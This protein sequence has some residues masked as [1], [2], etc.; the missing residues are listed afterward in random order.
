[1]RSPFRRTSRGGNSSRHLRSPFQAWHGGACL[2]RL[3][4]RRCF[5]F[6]PR[7]WPRHKSKKRTLADNRFLTFAT[8]IRV[9]QIEA[10]RSQNLGED[11]TALHTPEAVAAFRTAFARGWPDGRLNWALSWLAL[12]NQSDQYKAIRRRV[13]EYHASYGDEVTF[14]PGGYF[15]N[16]YNT[17]ELVSRDLHDGLA[18]ASA[19]VGGGY[20]PN[21][22]RRVSGR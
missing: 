17:R 13:A 10:T 22:Y 12:N 7:I 1:M 11:E 21:A 6:G 3:G 19:V 8:V 18:L 9:N 16:A 2:F 20:R 5:S 14:I 4:A 15:A